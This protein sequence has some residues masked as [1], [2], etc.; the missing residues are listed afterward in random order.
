MKISKVLRQ[1]A[2]EL[3][4]MKQSET[5]TPLAEDEV[6]RLMQEL[7][8]HQIELELQNEELMLAKSASHDIALKYTRFF[9]LAPIGYFALSYEGTI[10]EVNLCG[11]NMFGK[12]RLLLVSA[13]FGFFVSDNTKHIFNLFLG[14]I[15]S[16]KAFE[17]CEVTLSMKAT[18]PFTFN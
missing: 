8:I 4:R 3:H 17:T 1:K 5:K 16:S 11:A 2:E 18:Y 15:F 9:D 13:R 12:E 10:I 6:L 7:E 14:Q